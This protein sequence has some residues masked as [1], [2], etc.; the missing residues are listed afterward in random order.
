MIPSYVSEQVSERIPFELPRLQVHAHTSQ[1][2]AV[3][4]S[5][6]SLVSDVDAIAATFSIDEYLRTQIPL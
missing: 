3:E 1:S 5:Q 2:E 4:N 6:N